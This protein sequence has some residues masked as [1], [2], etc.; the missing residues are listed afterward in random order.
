MIKKSLIFSLV[1]I[2]LLTQINAYD[3]C[4]DGQIGENHLRLIS[5]DDMLKEN[6]KEWQWHNSEQ[7]EIELRVENKDDSTKDYIVELAFVDDDEEIELVE[8]DDDLEKSFQLSSGE[9]K[10]IALEFELID[11]IED[12]EYEVYAKFYKKGDENDE[13]V[14]NNEESVLI[15]KIE[16]CPDDEVDDDELEIRSL[17]DQLEDNKVE[18]E[19]ELND[20]IR[21]DVEVENKYYSER[22][23]VIELVLLSSN[24]T[25]MQL[26]KEGWSVKKT[27]KL[28]ENED[29][30]AEIDFRI[31]PEL[32][33]DDYTL[34]ARFYDE[35]DEDICTSLKAE[36]KSTPI[37]VHILR[38]E[39]NT[40]VTSAEGPKEIQAGTNVEFNATITNLG[41]KDEDKVLVILY[42]KLIGRFEQTIDDLDSGESQNL[43]FS[44]KIP[45]NLTEQNTYITFSTEYDY[46]TKDKRYEAISEDYIKHFIE[47]KE[48]EI[49]EVIINKTDNKTSEELNNL[50]E[51]N[52]TE[53]N[54]FEDIN[55]DFNEQQEETNLT[56]AITGN[57]VDSNNKQET[58]KDSS[59]KSWT[60]AILVL[61]M[62]GGVLFFLSRKKSRIDFGSAHSHHSKHSPSSAAP[63]TK[64]RKHSAKPIEDDTLKSIL[65]E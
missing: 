27:I 56:A 55:T 4:K 36:K 6:T 25:E 30:T 28:D 38:E 26:S 48:I 10:S 21:V 54:P 57:V 2:F 65:G 15:E 20:N 1:C 41:E 3:F 60:L 22:D 13:C 44:I 33:N 51:D 42:N 31:N 64:L 63:A 37:S 62:I 40:Q 8:D 17:K 53:I 34:Y 32:K 7:I 24:N 11:D 43:K 9:R 61:A 46:D 16:I 39:R 47:I 50:T 14:Q 59:I 23:F 29:Y 35:D 45:E 49:K 12:G 18:W 58:K 19:W 52:N 5:V